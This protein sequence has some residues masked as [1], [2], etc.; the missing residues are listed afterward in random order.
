MKLSDID[1]FEYAPPKIDLSNFFTISEIT[2]DDGSVSTVY[3][4]NDG[5]TVNGVTDSDDFLQYAYIVKQGDNLKLISYNKYGSIDYW[6]LIAK[7]N[8]ITDVL[9]TL[10]AG[11]SLILLPKEQ[12]DIIFNYFV[13]DR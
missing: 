11:S 2:N 12:M 9:E 6:W 1:D 3:N 7:V 8:G 4:L 13:K 5:V 10:E